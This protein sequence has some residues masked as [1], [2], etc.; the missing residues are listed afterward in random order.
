MELLVEGRLFSF[1]EAHSMGLVNAVYEAEGFFEKVME[2]A[3]SF[4]PPAK[5]SLAV[6]RIGCRWA[7]GISAIAA[8]E[9]RSCMRARNPAAPSQMPPRRSR[10][11]ERSPTPSATNRR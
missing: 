5:A 6:G 8:W 3:R 7:A 10:Q 9:G 1:E 2:Y 4:C 11:G